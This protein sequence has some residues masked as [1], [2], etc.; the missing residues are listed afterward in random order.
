MP[1]ISRRQA[2][3]PQA[4]NANTLVGGLFDLLRRTLGEPI[5]LEL[6]KKVAIN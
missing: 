6:V 2:L 5:A 3:A 1:Q 4:V